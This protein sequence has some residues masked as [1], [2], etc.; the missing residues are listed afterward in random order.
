MKKICKVE[1]CERNRYGNQE[2]CRQHYYQIRNHGKILKRTR[3]DPNE[4][5]VEG[6]IAYIQLYNKCCKPTEKAII[7]KEDVDKCRGYKWH[8]NK[9]GYVATDVK[10]KRIFLHNFVL[11][12]KASRKIQAD[13]KNRV[14]H[15]CR[16]TNL[17]LCTPNQNK[18]NACLISS[19]TS[20]FKGIYLSKQTNKWVAQITAN[21]K[22]YNLGH[23]VHKTEAAKA[24][25]KA[26]I[27]MHGE[28]AVL[29]LPKEI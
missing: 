27:K 25:D 23:F 18:Q 20:G 8:L 28:F 12:R 5:V 1:G 22:C 11:S 26:T 2:N 10:R 19:N 6:N 7:D 21:G 17:R 24:R 14:K 15:D 13:H 16:K 29:N 4:I 9:Y 3:F